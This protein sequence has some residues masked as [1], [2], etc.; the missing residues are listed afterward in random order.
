MFKLLLVP[1]KY[2]IRLLPK[3][4]AYERVNSYIYKFTFECGVQA[5][6]GLTGIG[7]ENINRFLSS[8]SHL[9]TEYCT[10]VDRKSVV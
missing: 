6:V 3:V 7:Q 5:L 8:N 2:E 1:T 4:F 9:I 10:A